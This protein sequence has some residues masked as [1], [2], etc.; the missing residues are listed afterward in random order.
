[1]NVQVV[2]APGRQ[3]QHRGVALL[4]PHRIGPAVVHADAAGQHEAQGDQVLGRADRQGVVV[5][6]AAVGDADEQV[7]VEPHHVPVPGAALDPVS[8]MRTP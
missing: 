4:D 8:V 2:V 7:V 6:V 5:V 3:G 1:M